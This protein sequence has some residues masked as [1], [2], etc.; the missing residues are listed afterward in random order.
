[1]RT[2]HVSIGELLEA[3]YEEL[4]EAY[5]DKELALVA[6]QALGDDLLARFARGAT[7]TA[8]VHAA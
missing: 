7:T 1:M 8:T 4:V 3:V 2:I 5:G 6:A